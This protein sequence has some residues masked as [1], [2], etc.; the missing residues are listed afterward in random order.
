MSATAC[1]PLRVH[2]TGLMQSG[3]RWQRACQPSAFPGRWCALHAIVCRPGGV[4]AVWH[5]SGAVRGC[6]S[7]ACGQVSGVS[8]AHPLGLAAARHWPGAVC[9]SAPRGLP[10][11]RARC[12][13][14]GAGGIRRFAPD[15]RINSHMFLGISGLPYY[16]RRHKTSYIRPYIV[17]QTKKPA[18]N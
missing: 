16:S 5:W 2:K 12:R 18:T 10:Q 6:L 1:A 9:P 8:P 13:V 3:L 14:L 17:K 4:R 15:S 7:V 11:N